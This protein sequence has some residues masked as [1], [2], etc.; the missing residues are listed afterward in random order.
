VEVK[1]AW[2]QYQVHLQDYDLDSVTEITGSPKELIEQ[3]A[4]GHRHHQAVLDQPGRGHQS[5][6]PRH[7][8]Q[9]RRLF[10]G[11]ADR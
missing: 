9:P 6:V 1:T 4:Q 2:S 7:R 5:L 3:L 11:D 10:A 8:S